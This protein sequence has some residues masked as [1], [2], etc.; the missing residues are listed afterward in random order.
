MIDFIILMIRL[1][2]IFL[3]LALARG[4]RKEGSYNSAA[5]YAIAAAILVFI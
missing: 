4:D 3:L 1:N 2:V 5:M